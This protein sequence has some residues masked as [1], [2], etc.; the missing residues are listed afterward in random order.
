MRQF[1]V[2]QFIDVEDKIIGPITTR[3]FLII[4]AGGLSLFIEFKL[5]D[6][7]L[8]IILGI[9]TIV[10]TLAFSFLKVNSMPLHFFIINI[11][12]TFK[13][14]K[15]RVWDKTLN[16][17]EIKE[18]LNKQQEEVVAVT[19]QIKPHV[20]LTHSRLQELSLIVD[21]GGAYKSDNGELEV[22]DTND[23]KI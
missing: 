22:K 10:F 13:R 12:Q 5:C 4:L 1:V 9:L 7:M 23:R 2:P 16:P 18:L 15:L 8:F 19:P 21:T 14:P 17:K 3:Q 6:L 11:I 20:T